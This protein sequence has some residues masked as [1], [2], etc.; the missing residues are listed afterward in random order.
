VKDITSVQLSP[1]ICVTPKLSP[2]QKKCTQLNVN[3]IGLL[4][5]THFSSLDR[6]IR[7]LNMIKFKYK[8][9]QIQN[10][11]LQRKLKRLNMKLKTS[12]ELTKYLQQKQLDST[13]MPVVTVSSHNIIGNESNQ[14]EVNTIMHDHDYFKALNE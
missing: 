5:P 10:H 3:T 2:S 14:E 12:D 6:A 13:Q 4:S 9:K 7:H 1:Q 8:Q 11:N